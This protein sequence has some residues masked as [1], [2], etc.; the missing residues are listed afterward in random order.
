[1]Q[2]DGIGKAC[3]DL[4]LNGNRMLFI[5]LNFHTFI[6]EGDIK[7]NGILSFGFFSQVVLSEILNGLSVDH[8]DRHCFHFSSLGE[9]QVFCVDMHSAILI[10]EVTSG[11]VDEVGDISDVPRPVESEG[12]I[13]GFAGL[14]R[15]GIRL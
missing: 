1:M 8:F 6:F 10:T 12:G 11:H 7:S 4:K 5:G 14:L 3:A 15:V 2:N 13:S 9:C